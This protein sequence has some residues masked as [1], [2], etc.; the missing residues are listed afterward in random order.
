MNDRREGSK[1]VSIA[2]LPI[3]VDNSYI[4]LRVTAALSVTITTV[5]KDEAELVD[6]EEGILCTWCSNL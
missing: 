1:W 4:Y 5:T 6:E 2:D 3:H